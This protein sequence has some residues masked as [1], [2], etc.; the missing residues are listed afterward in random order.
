M[1]LFLFLIFLGLAD[2]EVLLFF[3]LVRLCGLI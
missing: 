3:E 1:F 2:V